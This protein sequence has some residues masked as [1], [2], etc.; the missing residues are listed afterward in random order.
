MSNPVRECGQCG[1]QFW[2]INPQGETLSLCPACVARETQWEAEGEP[3]TEDEG[4][5]RFV[6]LSALP[7]NK[8]M[9][10][11]PDGARR[12]LFMPRRLEGMSGNPAAP[13]VKLVPP[14]PPAPP[15]PGPPPLPLSLP[16]AEFPR[17]G[18]NCPSCF[19]VLYIKDPDGY[20]GRAAP[21][22]YCRVA[23]LPPRMAPPS[24]FILIAEASSSSELPP[25]PR[26]S[27]WKPFKQ[28]DYSTGS[29]PVMQTPAG[30]GLVTAG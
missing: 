22:P 17:L 16:V 5:P 6:S 4:P 7:P 23:I 19:T 12:G 11:R 26:T 13:P 2:A 9:L 29:L 25:V 3:E 30:E 24:P 10:P 15:P 8:R 28:N 18:F 20:D 14:Q 1:Q 21:C 27:R